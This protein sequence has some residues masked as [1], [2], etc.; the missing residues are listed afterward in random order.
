MSQA[1]RSLKSASSESK[2][3]AEE[4][5]SVHAVFPNYYDGTRVSYSLKAIV[6]S[7][8]SPTVGTHAYVMAKARHVRREVSA[9]LPIAL[10]AYTSRLVRHPCAAIVRRFWHRMKPG[11]VAYFWMTNP[12]EVTR[13]LQGKGLWVVREMINCTAQR[14]RDELRRAYA[15]LGLPDGSDISDADIER[16]R[17]EL[18]A[19][20]AVF[21]PNPLVLESVLA[22]G[23]APGRC[24]R[25]SYGWSPQRIDGSSQHMPKAPGLNVLFVGSADVRKGFPWLLEAWAQA[26]IEGRLLLAGTIDAKTR[27]SYASILSRPDVMELGYVRDIGAVYRSADVFCFPSWEEGG[28]MVTIEAMAT[29]LPCIVTPMGSAGIVSEQ[30]DGALIVEPGDASAIASA[31]RRLAEDKA[32][33]EAMG[34]RAREIAAGYAWEQ[35]GRRRA[36]ALVRLREQPI[37]RA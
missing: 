33:R 26:G 23:V 8:A 19:A 9:L 16:E 14:R 31:M 21:C 4:S 22:Y 18:L 32:A 17:A 25:A 1:T 3:A 12:P 2:A 13:A 37:R 7:M 10:Y 24:I 36:E 30:T 6:E 11:D 5:F 35:V 29:G 20:D 34:R 28:P 27:S 15:L